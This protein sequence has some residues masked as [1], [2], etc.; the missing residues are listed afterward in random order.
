MRY[1]VVIFLGVLAVSGCAP[2]VPDSA[3]GVGFDTYDQYA[4]RQQQAARVRPQPQTVLPPAQNGTVSTPDNPQ[5]SR[6]QDFEAVSAERDIQADAAHIA[7][8]RQQYQLVTPQELQRP[9]GD[10]PSIIDFAL[11][12]NHPVGEKRFRRNPFTRNRAAEKCAGYRTDDVAQEEF[13]I[14]GGPEKDKLGLDP[15]GDGYACGWNPATYRQLV[16]N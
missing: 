1:S 8:A 14:A 4:A 10:G 2:P 11:S 9:D 7:A 15:D 5:L 3:S 12:Q 6:E 16:S 13:L